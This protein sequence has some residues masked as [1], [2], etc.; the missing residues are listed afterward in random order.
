[1]SFL[2]NVKF[3]RKTK[4]MNVQSF[5]EFIGSEL[6]KLGKL[7]SGCRTTEPHQMLYYKHIEYD[8]SGTVLRKKR[9]VGDL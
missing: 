8:L 7:I 5:I 6:I 3:Q 1:M 4:Q 9:M 2:T